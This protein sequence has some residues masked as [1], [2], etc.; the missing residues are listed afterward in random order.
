MGNHDVGRAFASSADVFWSMVPDGTT[1]TKEVVLRALEAVGE[2]YRGADAE[3][4]D[5][6]F[7][8]TTPLGRMVA[9]AFDAT[10][11]EMVFE[12]DK[13]CPW[14]DGPETRFRRH[15]NFC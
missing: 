3:F 5:E 15:F 1:P 6:L 7:D 10:P 11:E 2:R 14:Y 4:D 12:T 9:I 8:W 13:E